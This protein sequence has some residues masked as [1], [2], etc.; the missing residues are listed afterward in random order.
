MKTQTKKLYPKNA[1]FN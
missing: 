1:D